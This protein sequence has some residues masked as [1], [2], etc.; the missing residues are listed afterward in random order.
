MDVSDAPQVTAGGKARHVAAHAA[1]Q[2]RHAVAPGELL[3][4]QKLQYLRKGGEIFVLLPGGEDMG[5]DGKASRTKTV[6]HLGQIQPC[7]IAVCYHG[8]AA[9]G[10]RRSDQLSAAVQQAGGNGHGVFRLCFD[11]YGL[12]GV[13][14]SILP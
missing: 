12:N 9:G 11:R 2:R 3:L 8:G 13:C 6:F 10:Q 5:T 4:R 14:H 7:H 1:A